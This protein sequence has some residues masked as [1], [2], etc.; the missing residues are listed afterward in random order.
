M[1]GLWRCD[2]KRRYSKIPRGRNFDF[3]DPLNPL[4]FLA[5]ELFHKPFEVDQLFKSQQVWKLLDLHILLQQHLVEEGTSLAAIHLAWSTFL[6][7]ATRTKENP[8]LAGSLL[9]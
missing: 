3:Q 2:G 8:N 1:S 7:F 5:I 4:C 6:S 9:Y